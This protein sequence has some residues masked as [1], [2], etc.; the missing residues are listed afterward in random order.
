MTH[1]VIP[2]AYVELSDD[3]QLYTVAFTDDYETGAPVLY[4]NHVYYSSLWLLTP[5]NV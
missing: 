3:C 5:T 1:V 4:D 2:S